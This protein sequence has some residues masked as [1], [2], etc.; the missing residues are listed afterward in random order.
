MS[1]CSDP[2]QKIRTNKTIVSITEGGFHKTDSSH[3]YEIDLKY[4]VI[5]ANIAPDILTTIN[6]SIP[7]KFN[8]FINQK[9]FIEAH[10]NLPED[11]YSDNTDWKG[12]LTNTYKVN[13][14]DSLLFLTFSVY[15]Y[16]VGAAHG[17]TSQYSLRF[18]LSSGKEVSISDLIETDDAS[19]T[20]LRNLFNSHLPDSVCWGIQG[21]SNTLVNIQNIVF[22]PDSVIFYVDDY[23]LCPNAFGYSNIRFSTD[24]TEGVLAAQSFSYF[25]E[26]E[27]VVDEG[28]IATH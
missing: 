23:S 7:E 18:D 11:F 8:S 4:P 21:D 12:L 24:Q 13:Q 1:A 5:D 16:F 28:E 15:Q 10:L 25:S 3:A 19:L 14:A 17:S 2:I 26:I 9:A 6:N 22:I 27:P 20:S